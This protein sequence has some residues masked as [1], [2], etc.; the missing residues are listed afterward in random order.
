M[1]SGQ[2]HCH[3]LASIGMADMQMAFFSIGGL[4]CFLGR[5]HGVALEGRNKVHSYYPN[6]SAALNMQLAH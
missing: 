6:I 2:K 5:L 1:S 3:S 4:T